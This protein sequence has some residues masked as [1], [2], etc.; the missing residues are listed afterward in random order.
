MPPNNQNRDR[1]G[2]VLS[3]PLSRFVLLAFLAAIILFLRNPA[4]LDHP[5]FFAEDGLVFFQEQVTV[6]SKA[7]LHP[8]AGYLD[9]VPRLLAQLDSL[10]P[11]RDIPFFYALESILIAGSCCSVFVFD[12]FQAVLPSG[13]LRG[14]LCLLTAAAFPEEEIVANLT[15][16]QWFLVLAAVPLTILPVFSRSMFR[17]ALL[18]LLA[19]VISLS[20][21]LTIVLIPLLLWRTFRTRR[22]ES[23]DIGLLAGTAIEWIVIAL[24]SASGP[25]P[26]HSFHAIDNLAFS[27]L[28]AFANQIVASSL[29]GSRRTY[30][31]FLEGYKAIG[32]LLLVAFTCWQAVLYTKGSLRYKQLVRPMLWLIFAS[33]LLANV[34][35]MGAVFTAI[36]SVQPFGAHRYFLLSCWCFAF[37]LIWALE[38]AKPGWPAW[39]KAALIAAIFLYGATGNFPLANHTAPSWGQFAPQVASWEAD[40]RA[41]REHPAVS[42]PIDPPGWLIQLPQLSR[43]TL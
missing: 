17:R 3:H 42:I 15:N 24:H 30:M 36:G 32:L 22:L 25:V 16:L 33:V 7:I 37:L 21:P 40:R 8:Y 10:L 39:K 19:L 6:G 2:T 35:E 29:I 26:L 41:G 43:R 23:F 12:N 38:N 5:R 31:F 34:R 18:L 28:V 1:E 13:L 20:A 11:V 4:Y 27:S 9:I 14:L